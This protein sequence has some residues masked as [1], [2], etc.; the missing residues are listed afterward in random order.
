MEAIIVTVEPAGVL[1]HNASVVYGAL[2]RASGLSL[3]WIGRGILYPIHHGKE[4]ASLGAGL[5][6]PAH[7]RSHVCALEFFIAG[8]QRGHVERTLGKESSG[9]AVP[10]LVSAR[11]RVLLT[12]AV[13]AAWLHSERDRGLRHSPGAGVP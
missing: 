10:G 12:F 8:G 9:P 4:I 1:R 6:L 13:K 2:P 7:R 3:L 5:F 11:G